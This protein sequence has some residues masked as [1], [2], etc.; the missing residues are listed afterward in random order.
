MLVPRPVHSQV[1]ERGDP[2]H[3][4]S[5]WKYYSDNTLPSPN[6]DVHDFFLQES[7]QATWTKS[8]KPAIVRVWT[9]GLSAAAVDKV[10]NLPKEAVDRDAQKLLLGYQ[11]PFAVLKKLTEDERL[12]VII[13]EEVADDQLV[14][15]EI[16]A[17]VEID[18]EHDFIRSLSIVVTQAGRFGSSDAAGHWEHIVPE[19]SGANLSKIVCSSAL[20]SHS[21]H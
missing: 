12:G 3:I 7:V 9:K 6:T 10:A 17:L 15:P 8:G 2:L 20:G 11:P 16:K 13:S 1:T 19:S 21:K 18:C 5:G 14:S 4:T